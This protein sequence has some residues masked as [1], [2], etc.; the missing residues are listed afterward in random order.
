MAGMPLV[1]FALPLCRVPITRMRISEQRPKWH[2]WKTRDTGLL[3]L[4]VERGGLPA[5]HMGVRD[6]GSVVYLAPHLK[7]QG[8]VTRREVIS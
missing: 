6:Q 1:A 3:N 5:V 7:V 4:L 8:E 2:N